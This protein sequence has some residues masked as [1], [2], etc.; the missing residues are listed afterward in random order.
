MFFRLK[1]EYS[2]FLLDQ[3]SEGEFVFIEHWPR[4]RD[5]AASNK[6]LYDMVSALLVIRNPDGTAW[7]LASVLLKGEEWYAKKPRP[8]IIGLI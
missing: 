7:R 1:S 3:D 8:E 6:W 5:S 2:R 4:I